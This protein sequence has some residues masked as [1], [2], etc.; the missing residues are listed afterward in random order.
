MFYGQTIFIINGKTFEKC[1]CKKI[2]V[3]TKKIEKDVLLM[4]MEL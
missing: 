3:D 1:N 4:K 2:K